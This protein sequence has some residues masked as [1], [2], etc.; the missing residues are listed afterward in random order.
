MSRSSLSTVGRSSA[1]APRCDKPRSS[2][3]STYTSSYGETGPGK[4][5]L[6]RVIHNNGAR[7][8]TRS[9]RSTVAALRT[10]DRERAVFRS[11]PGAHSTA[12]R[13]ISQGGRPRKGHPFLDESASCPYGAQL[14]FF[15]PCRQR[16]TT[17]AAPRDRQAPR[18]GC[19]RHHL[20]LK[21]R[22]SS[23]ASARTCSRLRC[24][25]P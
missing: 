4:S 1:L 14:S 17:P 16:S 5:Q 3:R 20:D 24:S 15:Q 7:A 6:A 10:S 9:S 23:A 12:T 22:S 13:K 21:E 11:S 25:P 2:P 19:R 18:C 8:S